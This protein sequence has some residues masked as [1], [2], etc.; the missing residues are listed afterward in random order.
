MVSALRFALPLCPLFVACTIDSG[1]SAYCDRAVTLSGTVAGDAPYD[2][3]MSVQAAWFLRSAEEA[4][5]S[6]LDQEVMQRMGLDASDDADV[7]RYRY[8]TSQ[9]DVRMLFVEE[10]S[11]TQA[12]SLG[13]TIGRDFGVFL[14]DAFDAQ[15]QPGAKVQVFDLSAVEAARRAG[16]REA[17]GDAV[18][19]AIDTMRTNGIV[20]AL[21]AFA[22]DRSGEG[23]ESSLI[24]LLSANAIYATGGSVSLEGVLD[25]QGAA[26]AEI[27][28]PTNAIDSF[29]LQ[30]TVDFGG[31]AVELGVSCAKA[32]I[33]E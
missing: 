5:L 21:V 16:D 20:D 13:A 22:P 12:G 2:D 25:T 1:D 15:L 7:Q 8:F 32:I 19:T 14:F 11:Q 24:V 3:G 23:A 29:G 9:Y 31:D 26:L 18:R 27:A 33:S 6:A 30:G 4:A 10:L 17:L 28:H